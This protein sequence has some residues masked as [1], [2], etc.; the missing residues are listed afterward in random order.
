[1]DSQKLHGLGQKIEHV[2]PHVEQNLFV[3]ITSGTDM[4]LLRCVKADASRRNDCWDGERLSE[5]RSSDALAEN[6]HR[7]LFSLC[8]GEGNLPACSG[9]TQT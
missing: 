5:C 4:H 8:E 1:M 6:G 2:A 3:R 7:K 9:V